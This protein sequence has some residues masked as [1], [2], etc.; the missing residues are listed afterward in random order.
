MAT[1]TIEVRKRENKTMYAVR[2]KCPATGKNKYYKSFRKKKDAQKA[3][4]HLY[5]LLEKGSL[6]I[7]QEEKKPFVTMTLAEVADIC[8]EEWRDLMLTEEMAKSTFSN[9]S[10]I[11]KKLKEDLGEKNVAQITT[12]SIKTYLKDTVIETSAVTANRR[13]Y[14]LKR[15]FDKAQELKAVPN[16]P[17]KNMRYY[18]EKKH[19]RSRFL[20]REEIDR[21]LKACQKIR[22]KHYMPAVILLGTDL[23]ASRQEILDVKWYD[24]DFKKRLITL[25]RTK[26]QYKRTRVMSKRLCAALQHWQEHLAYMRHK[27]NITDYVEANV[28]CHLDGTP[29]KEFR[30]AWEAVRRLAHIHD[31]H[32][33]DLRHTFSSNMLFAGMTIKDIQV[34]IGHRDPRMTDRYTHLDNRRENKALKALEDY[35]EGETDS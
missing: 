2:F 8:Q 16:S 27:K 3:E 21:L 26:N 4:M 10:Y 13:M 30:K 32:F 17:V 20:N 34:C 31:C 33:H 22:G 14:I 1:V 9:F 23:G 7:V 5:S 12:E 6:D 35:Y 29:R 28:I 24:I 19:Q 25:F 18:S 15:V 11:L